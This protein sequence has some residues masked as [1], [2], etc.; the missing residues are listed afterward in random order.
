MDESNKPPRAGQGLNKVAEVT[1]LNIKCIDK[2]TRD[3]YMDGPRVNKY[4]DMLMKAAKNQ[5]AERVL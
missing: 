3:Q 1:L 5:G 2:R 4:R